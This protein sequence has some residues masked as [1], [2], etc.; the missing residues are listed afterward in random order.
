MR[1]YQ[2]DPITGLPILDAYDY[3]EYNDASAYV[4]YIDIVAG[5]SKVIKATLVVD[6]TLDPDEYDIE[7]GG[8]GYLQP[9]ESFSSQL[10]V[11]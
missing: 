7:L 8:D 1:F 10:P 11:F 6:T 2:L 9:A 3:I 4:D 5:R